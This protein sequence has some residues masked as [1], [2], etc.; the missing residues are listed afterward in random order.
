M[1]KFV[2][3]T[4]QYKKNQ[5][6][7]KLD[8]TDQFKPKHKPNVVWH[9]SDND[10]TGV[11]DETMDELDIDNP[12]YEN[13]FY[14]D[15]YGKDWSQIFLE[16]E[17]ARWFDNREYYSDEEEEDYYSGEEDDYETDYDSEEEEYYSTYNPI[18][19]KDE[20]D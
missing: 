7:L 10:S 20:E 5:D 2:E 6:K 14:N 15:D 11:R 12:H 9:F 1:D 13:P 16:S 8:K 18:K 4:K 17:E 19:N 3:I